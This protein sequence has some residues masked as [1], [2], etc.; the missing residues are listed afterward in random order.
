MG[1]CAA[2]KCRN[3]P[4]K[5]SGITF[6]KFPRD[7]T[8]REEWV[9][10]VKRENFK[11]SK[12][13]RLCSSHFEES[14]LDRTGQTVRLRENAVPTIF[15]HSPDPPK[16]RSVR[17]RPAA[18]SST[19]A[20]PRKVRTRTIALPAPSS[21]KD[22]A[23]KPK[24][25]NRKIFRPYSAS[26]EAPIVDTP[27][28]DLAIE[29]SVGKNSASKDTVRK[30]SASKN[31]G[32]KDT[33]R[34]DSASK[35]SGSKDTVSK[36]SGSKNTC[37]KNTVSKDTPSKN[38]VRKGTVSKNSRRKN[39]ASKNSISKNTDNKN[40]A[41]KKNGSV[42]A[43][44]DADRPEDRTGTAASDDLDASDDNGGTEDLTHTDR[45]HDKNKDG[46]G[47]SVEQ[48]RGK[49]GQPE[50]AGVSSLPSA[51]YRHWKRLG[52][53]QG[54]HEDR[55]IA[56]F[57][58]K[59]YEYTSKV[60]ASSITGV[61]K[62]CDT[63]LSTS[64]HWCNWTVTM[65][66]PSSSSSHQTSGNSASKEKEGC[67]EGVG[68]RGEEDG[69]RYPRCSPPGTVRSHGMARVKEGSEDT[70][71][72]V[73]G[74][75]TWTERATGRE[76]SCSVEK[77]DSD[78]E[79]QADAKDNITDGGGICPPGFL[80]DDEDIVM[81]GG[82]PQ[83][84]E[85][86]VSDPHHQR[87][88]LPIEQDA[89]SQGCKVS[90][91]HQGH[92]AD[93]D[94]SCRSVQN[95]LEDNDLFQEDTE[96]DETASVCLDTEAGY[97]DDD[98]LMKSDDQ[99]ERSAEGDGEGAAELKAELSEGRKGLEGEEEGEEEDRVE[100]KGTMEGEEGGKEEEES[101][102]LSRKGS[103]LADSE[104]TPQESFVVDMNDGTGEGGGLD[105]VIANGTVSDDTGTA[106]TDQ[107]ALETGEAI[108]FDSMEAM[109]DYLHECGAGE[110]AVLNNAQLTLPDQETVGTEL[111]PF[112]GLLNHV[113][114]EQEGERT[115]REDDETPQV[116]LCLLGPA[117]D[118]TGDVSDPDDS[119]TAESCVQS[120]VTDVAAETRA[121]EE[122]E[123]SQQRVPDETVDGLVQELV[124]ELGQEEIS[125]RCSHDHDYHLPPSTAR[126][127]VSHSAPSARRRR[128]AR[129][130]KPRP[131][132]CDLC[133]KA[134]ATPT[135]LKSHKYLHSVLK[136]NVCDLCGKSFLMPEYLS[137]HRVMDHNEK[138][139]MCDKCDAMF[140]TASELKRHM[141]I[142]DQKS[143]PCDECGKV[144]KRENHLEKHRLTHTRDETCVCE[145]CGKL[146][147]SRNKL[148]IH[149]KNNHKPNIPQ[150]CDQCGKI[151]I[152]SSRL[153]RHKQSHNTEKKFVCDICGK[154][155]QQDFNLRRH[156]KN[157]FGQRQFVCETCGA[158]FTLASN[159]RRHQRR[160]LGLKPHKCPMCEKAF[161]QSY[162]LKE[163]ILTHYGEKSFP[164]DV[165]KRSY[166][167]ER[168]LRAHKKMTHEK[169]KKNKCDICDKCFLYPSML[170][171]H[172]VVHTGGRVYKP[173]KRLP[174]GDAR[175]PPF[176]CKTCG[177]V[178]AMRSNMVRH[179][180]THTGEKRFHCDI[181]FKSFTMN[182]SLKKHKIIHTGL[183]PFECD[184]CHKT[185][186]EKGTLTK[187]KRIH[188][189]Q[190]SV[191][192]K[193]TVIPDKVVTETG[194]E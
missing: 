70:K 66:A 169:S 29:N 20:P 114:G 165:C 170:K 48:Q 185:F 99:F 96:D 85:D 40:S 161:T 6:H 86:D 104:D 68:D 19:S 80:K 122:A 51:A 145:V 134:V 118:G 171:L 167:S 3:C 113:T 94:G 150:V 187:H 18:D 133:G 7:P 162:W 82:P 50:F 191:P 87:G 142:H 62:T 24:R 54:L 15:D 193:V 105:S 139:F 102:V 126:P 183:R 125:R 128:R 186:T 123:P 151:C 71:G 28:K 188:L 53:Q 181:C 172:Q 149:Y 98:T 106:Q 107:L 21:K 108:S 36:N 95:D 92:S 121:D 173:R 148:S 136:P 38:S 64:C 97:G 132:V 146:F 147:S 154:A 90:P 22:A 16:K 76:D 69:D 78:K 124:L 189:R 34:K 127:L 163:H 166:W 79:L 111:S 179:Q 75:T 30:D 39:T 61:C 83:G 164:C 67:D 37:S 178:F 103:G 101:A 49:G 35:N 159:M 115:E 17:K 88:H 13:S 176:P 89:N 26:E 31:S 57:F 137:N 182:C 77:T 93:K 157:H 33:V 180:L 1:C 129:N 160:H 41:R 58:L 130:T 144:F 158:T 153:S 117:D 184:V 156:K 65:G 91:E 52:A 25:A 12:F 73:E 10:A 42:T 168:A 174:A 32:S 155:F 112:S 14:C 11:V 152:N 175:G 9:K 27:R 141:K 63:P 43:C 45:E 44:K 138:R 120:P 140:R 23:S 177:R 192:D 84:V 60:L 81:S 4:Q 55:D 47:I 59:Y 135:S 56:C 72:P 119:Q 100:G 190:Q 5:G 2:L 131:Y 8:Q 109:W 110:I 74:E 143:F 116:F 46:G 194:P